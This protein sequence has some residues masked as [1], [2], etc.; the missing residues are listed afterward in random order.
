[1]RRIGVSVQDVRVPYR[2][3]GP[4]VRMGPIGPI[5]PI[6]PIRKR[7]RGRGAPALIHKQLRDDC[8]EH[9]ADDYFEAG[10]AL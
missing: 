10:V 9:E 5:R 8:T 6:R 2:F 7:R 1:M 3:I 4:I